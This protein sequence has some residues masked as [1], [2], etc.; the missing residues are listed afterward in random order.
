MTGMQRNASGSSNNQAGPAR[1]E[2]YSFLVLGYRGSIGQRHYANLLAMGCQVEG[3]DIKDGGKPPPRHFDA[4]VVATPTE[5]HVELA[6]E[7]LTRG[8]FVYVE[9]P[10]ARSVEE[11]SQLA[12]FARRVYVGVQWPHHPAVA[13]LRHHV[14]Q[15]R[16]VWLEASQNICEWPNPHLRQSILW[17][18]GPHALAIVQSFVDLGKVWHRCF[19][20]G[21][22]HDDL[23]VLISS[24]FVVILDWFARP[25]IDR[26]RVLGVDG[27]CWVTDYSGVWSSDRRLEVGGDLSVMYRFALLDFIQCMESGRV[28]PESPNS[29]ES[30]V[31]RLEVISGAVP[32]GSIFDSLLPKSDP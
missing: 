4:V 16:F 19:R 12:D 18:S 28:P 7:A 8:A 32:W 22:G 24:N 13:M 27:R 17:D 31:R 11:A 10:V 29:L 1:S 26:L 9:K 20:L 15:C 3:Y 25:R 30:A 23:A 2:S 5:T 14:G 6:W 21:T